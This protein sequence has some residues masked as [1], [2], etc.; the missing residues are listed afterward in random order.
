MVG[1]L[2]FR[3]PAGQAGAERPVGAAGDEE[4][5]APDRDRA[6]GAVLVVQLEHRV[7]PVGAALADLLELS[8]EVLVAPRERLGR[9]RDA[10]FLRPEIRP[11]AAEGKPKQTRFERCWLGSMTS[12]SDMRL[13]AACV[14]GDLGNWRMRACVASRFA[15]WL[16]TSTNSCV[17][18]TP[19]ACSLMMRFTPS[20]SR[21][22]SSSG[23]RSTSATS[24]ARSS[25]ASGTVS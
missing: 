18:S 21:C 20:R 13:M 2:V 17:A 16:C 8:P 15:S 12:A 24:S 23:G 3:V 19:L 14:S 5:V 1:A 22:S 25:K 7:L 11:E 10:I 9:A 4:A 6:R